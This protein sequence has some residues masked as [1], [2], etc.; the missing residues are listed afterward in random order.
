MSFPLLPRENMPAHL[1]A[2]DAA[3]QVVVLRHDGALAV[4]ARPLGHAETDPLPLTLGDAAEVTWIGKS[5]EQLIP[6]EI[7]AIGIEDAYET[8]TLRSA[9]LPM[10]FDRRAYPRV[11]LNVPMTLGIVG[12][13]TPLAECLLA[14]LSEVGLRARLNR[15]DAAHVAAELE[16][17]IEF[18]ADGFDFT[19]LGRAVRIHAVDGDDDLADVVVVFDLTPEGRALLRTALAAQE[20][21]LV[22]WPPEFP[23]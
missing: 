19:M 5:G 14:D 20:E 17:A 2:G 9:G 10:E 6:V 16:L 23:S 3:H 7:V 8:W 18:T 11:D 12:Q 15:T 13:L 4:V 1:H 22:E 21:A